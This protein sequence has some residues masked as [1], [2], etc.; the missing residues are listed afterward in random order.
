MPASHKSTRR[1]RNL[2]KKN[3][4]QLSRRRTLRLE[5]LEARLALV[6]D[7][8]GTVFGDVNSNG[9]WEPLLGE[10]GA[11]NQFVYLDSNSNGA[12]DTGEPNTLTSGTG[13]GG[14]AGTNAPAVPSM[15]K[16]NGGSTLSSI[17]IE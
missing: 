14:G 4:G 1:L 7:I 3:L 10:V 17:I 12:H 9:L 8:S 16:L 13:T 2:R 15:L 6:G 11:A 5:T